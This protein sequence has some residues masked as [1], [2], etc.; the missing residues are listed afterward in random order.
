MNQIK[1]AIQ[2][3][4]TSYGLQL[5]KVLDIEDKAIREKLLPA[6]WGQTQISDASHLLVFCGYADV[7]DEHVDEY[8]NLKAEVS[9]IDVANLKGYGD[10]VK[11]TMS[12]FPIDFKQIWTAKQ[13]YIALGNAMASLC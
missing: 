4:A 11:V 9:N 3:T 6:S 2:L 8:M 12:K 7:K 5:F 1:E 13:T 10:F